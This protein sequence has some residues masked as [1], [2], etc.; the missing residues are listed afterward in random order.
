M[1]QKALSKAPEFKIDSEI[2]TDGI[3]YSSNNIMITPYL[4]AITFRLT[5]FPFTLFSNR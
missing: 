4:D 2:Y 3:L 5:Y 1:Y